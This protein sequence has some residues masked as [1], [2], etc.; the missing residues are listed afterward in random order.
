M[1]ISTQL[2][3]HIAYFVAQLLNMEELDAAAIAFECDRLSTL[4]WDEAL[5]LYSPSIRID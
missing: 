2:R 1:R 4:A 3:T 5:E